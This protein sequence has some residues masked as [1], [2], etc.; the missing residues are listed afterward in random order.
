MTH[1]PYAPLENHLRSLADLPD[2]RANWCPHDPAVTWSDGI[3]A[4]ILHTDRW[5]ICRFR[6]N[7]LNPWTADRIATQLN[8][9]PTAIWGDAW[10][11]ACA[12][13]EER[14][15]VTSKRPFNRPW[16]WPTDRALADTG[17][18]A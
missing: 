16:R 18:V 7:G 17:A 12:A 8:V 15:D 10:T 2:Q 5:R 9:H 13:D 11:D 4:R 14:R 1:L 3:A 6:A